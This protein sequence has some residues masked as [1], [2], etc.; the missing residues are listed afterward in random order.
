MENQRQSFDEEIECLFHEPKQLR[1]CRSALG[2]VRLSVQILESHKFEKTC[3]AKRAWANELK[4]LE[5]GMERARRIRFHR[6]RAQH[7]LTH[8]VFHFSLLSF[9]LLYH[10][11]FLCNRPLPDM[12]KWIEKRR[13]S[14]GSEK[15]LSCERIG[16][17]MCV[18]IE[19]E[20]TTSKADR[21]TWKVRAKAR[22]PRVRIKTYEFLLPRVIQ[23]VS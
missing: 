6:R 12:T 2:W 11:L 14:R 23:F 17:R 4:G 16:N 13:A 3:C 22:V 15:S 9:F 19:K 18:R 8:R 7:R 20:P 10:A 5:K 21:D 1:K